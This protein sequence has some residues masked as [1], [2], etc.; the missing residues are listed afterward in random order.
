M[1][2]PTIYRAPVTAVDPDDATKAEADDQ[3]AYGEVYNPNYHSTTVIE[4]LAGKDYH[5]FVIPEGE[6]LVLPRQPQDGIFPVKGG[7]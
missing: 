4:S 3:P 2:E 1:Q 6:S 7:N 5:D